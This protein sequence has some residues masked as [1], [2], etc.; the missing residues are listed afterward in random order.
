MRTE[1]WA[2]PKPL[3]LFFTV[4]FETLFFI[5]NAESLSIDFENK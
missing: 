5:Q 4:N 1:S 2:N 3:K